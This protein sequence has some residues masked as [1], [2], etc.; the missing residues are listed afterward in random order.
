MDGYYACGWLILDDLYLNQIYSGMVVLKSKKK[1]KKDTQ[2]VIFIGL[3]FTG[4]KVRAIG[5]VPLGSAKICCANH[6]NK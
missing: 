3:C 2:K 6:K 1:K 5:A 4:E